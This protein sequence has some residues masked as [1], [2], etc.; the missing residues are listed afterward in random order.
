MK[1]VSAEL[2]IGLD[3][4]ARSPLFAGRGPT[5]DCEIIGKPPRIA[6]LPM[7]AH[8]PAEVRSEGIL[9]DK[10]VEQEARSDGVLE[11]KA[12]AARELDRC[13]PLGST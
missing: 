4:Q 1:S 2:L 5:K 3:G 9:P 10:H 12:S 13:V 6:R 7:Q 8:D 11:P